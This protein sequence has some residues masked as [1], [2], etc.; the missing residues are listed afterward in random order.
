M[1]MLFNTLLPNDKAHAISAASLKLFE[2]L[3]VIYKI[4]EVGIAPITAILSTD[5]NIVF[6]V[7]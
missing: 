7:L 5:S 6:R 1:I 3:Q 2:I 4:I